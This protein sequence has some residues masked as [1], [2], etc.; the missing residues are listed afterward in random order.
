M[1]KKDV[2]YI[3]YPVYNGISLSHKNE[4]NNAI[5]SNMDGSRDCC[6]EWSQSDTGRQISY[7]IV[8]MWNLKDEST[9][10]LIYETE[11]ESQTQKRNLWL[12][13]DMIG[14][15]INWEIVTDIE[16]LLYIKQ[17]TNKNLLYS[18]GDSAQYSIVAYMVKES[19]KREW[20]YVYV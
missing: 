7:G 3:Y 17:I 4:Q 15:G 13:G 10:E 8:Y 12:P 16:I 5:C 20:I 11:V 2:V 6:T 9:N 14:G 19:K 18:P 1:D